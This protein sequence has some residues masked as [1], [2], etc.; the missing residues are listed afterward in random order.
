M[1]LRTGLLIFL[2]GDVHYTLTQL[3][4]VLP[5]GWPEESVFWDWHALVF[6][7]AD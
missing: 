6:L 5:G 1:E 3:R 7:P 4:V 2:T